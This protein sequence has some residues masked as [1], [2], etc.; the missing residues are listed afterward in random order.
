MNV[1]GVDP[2]LTGTGLAYQGESE[3]VLTPSAT[4]IRGQLQRMNIIASRVAIHTPPGT[5]VVMEGPGFSRGGQKGH[6]AL[7]GLWWVLAATIVSRGC[8]LVEIKPNVLKK[9][10]TGKGNADKAAMRAA[11]HWHTR[12]DVA[13]PDRVDAL[14]LREVGLQLI[15]SDEA[16]ILEPEQVEAIASLRSQ[17]PS[18]D[19]A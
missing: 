17:L 18:G 7:A 3:K 10:A 8:H 5:L 11:W 19:A 14:W 9:F 15:D 13:D 2:S 12:Q 1:V 6:H 16:L 4:T